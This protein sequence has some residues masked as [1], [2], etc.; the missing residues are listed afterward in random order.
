MKL[1]FT[2]IKFIGILTESLFQI[3]MC[4]LEQQ[5]FNVDMNHLESL[6]KCKIIIQ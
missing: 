1:S 5:I 6:L 4:Y 3:V 2:S